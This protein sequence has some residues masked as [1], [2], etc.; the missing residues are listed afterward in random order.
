MLDHR[1]GRT[2]EPLGRLRLAAVALLASGL[3]A[4]TGLIDPGSTERAAPEAPPALAE[5]ESG[6]P[7][8]ATRFPRLTHLQWENTV[9]DLLR[10]DSAPGLASAF[11][12]DPPNG[13]FDNDGARLTVGT[14][15]GADYQRAAE[16]LARQIARTPAAL[17]RIVPAELPS[18]LEPR[19]R[20]FL[21]KF[22]RRADR[23]P[24]TAAEVDGYVALFTQGRELTGE[25]DA[26]AAGAELVLEAMLQSPHFLYRVES[27]VDE[28]SGTIPLNSFEIAS[29]L[30]Y[31]LWN[32][33]PDDAL[34]EAAARDELAT[35]R[36]LREQAARMLQDPRAEETVVHFH[37]KLLGADHYAGLNRDPG[38]FP[39]FTATLG[40]SMQRETE[41]FVKEV[42]FAEKKGL[43]RLLTAPYTFMNREL[44]KVY[45]ATGTFGSELVRIET[46][47][48]KRAG[49]L[50]QSGF[51]ASKS[52]DLHPDPI[53]RGVFVNLN[54]LCVDLPTPPSTI[55][56]VPEANASQT[57]RQRV[58]AHTG[59]GTC[60][61]S[62][63]GTYINPVGYAFEGYDALGQARDVDNGQPVDATGEYT[64]EDGRRSFNGAIELA[65][66]ISNSQL[67]HACYVKR[68]MEYTLA[69][70]P[71][72]TDLKV[73]EELGE[74]SL[75]EGL[76]TQEIVTSLVQSE[77]FRTRAPQEAGQ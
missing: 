50:T 76:S 69:R 77:P 52:Y 33:M 24:L 26:F 49:L 53:H 14:A 15:L 58:E 16:A 28:K 13:A 6:G 66:L 51:L 12:P 9:R 35:D 19:A 27:S 38:K 39:N 75:R 63:H 32:S 17:A 25:S 3:L 31:A 46:D 72:G 71:G 62:C 47:P 21:E 34:L 1:E 7:V 10:L 48:S 23:R 5:E 59:K 55:T 73:V 68:W 22:G 65:Q 70:A 41:L 74:R 57:N 11:V 36:G 8:Q 45:G 44:A 54:I 2:L 67:A 60:G 30:S 40:K 29:R 61:A 4:C 42:V 37:N 56:A 18:E 64:F 43:S 20:G